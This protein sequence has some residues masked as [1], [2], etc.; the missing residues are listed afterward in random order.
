MVLIQCHQLSDLFLHVE[1]VFSIFSPFPCDLVTVIFWMWRLFICLF[2]YIFI[3]MR[4]GVL[5][6]FNANGI[7]DVDS[8]CGCPNR[9]SISFRWWCDAENSVHKV[10]WGVFYLLCCWIIE[11]VVKHFVGKGRQREK[12]GG[13]GENRTL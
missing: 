6:F 11:F 2:F 7:C 8:C 5:L 10:C 1:M 13:G 12:E 9:C 3:L 4:P